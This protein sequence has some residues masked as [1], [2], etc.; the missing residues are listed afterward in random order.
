MLRPWKIEILLDPQSD[1]A[2]YLQLADAIIGDIKSGRLTSGMALPGSR[3]LAKDLGLNRNTVVDAL[4]V[5]INEGWLLTKER[6]GTFVAPALPI[7]R[8]ETR[9]PLVT[10]L[11]E[12]ALP[13]Y[14]IQ[15]DDGVPNSRIAPVEELARAYR[16]FFNRKAK[17]Q[18]M[19]YGSAYGDVDFREGITKMLNQQRSMAI[20]AHQLCVTRGSQMA[21]YLVSQ[22]L[23]EEGDY[24]LVESP[25]YQAAWGA[26]EHA[27]AKLL[28]VG[29]DGEGLRIADV[30]TH[31][32]SGK[33]IKAIYCTP[34]RQYPTTVTLSLQR[35]MQLISLSNKHD[36]T[37]IE[38]DYDN[39]FHFGYRPVLPMS[40]SSL[41]KNYVYLGTM[42]KVV[43]PVLRI[44][45]L[46]THNASLLAQVGELRK[47]IDVQGDV[48]M[49][50]AVLQL[51]QD[52]TIKRHL[53]KASNYY[54]TKRDYMV[55]LLEKHLS[56]TVDF[57][58]PEG[59]LAVWITAKRK[60][61]WDTVAE[62]LLI[63]GVKIVQPGHY[64]RDANLNGIRLGY[65]S[66]SEEQLETGIRAL[67]EVLVSSA[68][69][70]A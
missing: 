40:S 67:A 48:I 52:G 17:W 23:F 35:R 10:P 4:D 51:M 31:L 30:Q 38:D 29:V 66:L 7:E 34:H 18:M 62:R 55:A 41:L 24:V 44:G 47:T 43:A 49:E 3:T 59:G 58:V 26:I 5:L 22:C 27:G 36:F 68:T 60:V 64:S 19:G 54:K 25:G 8:V 56:D 37:I 69:V 6:S 50:Q 61:N 53:K 42:S 11:E 45:Y 14:V 32:A 63:K 1:K 70:K 46:V 39:E 13:D 28:P 9:A 15:F 65:G 20:G 12:K 21:L 16:Q 2:I 33:R 57:I